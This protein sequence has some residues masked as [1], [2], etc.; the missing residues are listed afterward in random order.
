MKKLFAIAL[1]FA[2]I[3]TFAID[4][5]AAKK[6]DPKPITGKI[7]CFDDIVTGNFQTWTLDSAK[8]ASEKGIMFVLLTKKGKTSKI[9]FI[10]NEDGS[11]ASKKV[12]KYAH[13]EKVGV[14]GKSK[15]VN[16]VNI[17]IMEMIEGM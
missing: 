3:G 9:Y 2:L 16:G 11:N 17:I 15:I 14:V 5:F 13:K 6:N 8:E 4:T 7:V 12:S 10:F 1:I